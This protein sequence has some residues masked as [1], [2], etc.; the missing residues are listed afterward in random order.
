MAGVAALAGAALAAGL[1]AG[2]AGA[3]PLPPAAVAEITAIT[4]GPRYPNATWGIAID[5]A[6]TGERLYGRNAN[7]MFVPASITKLAQ[8]AAALQSYGP[9]HRLRTPVHR[10]GRVSGGRLDGVLSLV[11]SGDTSFGLRDRGN[12]LVYADGGADHNEAN[13]LGLVKSVSGDPLK[14]LNALAKSVRKSGITRASD[15]VIDDRLWQTQNWPDGPV[16]PMWVNENLIDITVR[17]GARGKRASISWRPRTAAYR[18]VSDVRT[19]TATN[20]E[21]GSTEEGVVRI[22]GTIAAGGGSTVR[23]Y[24]VDDAT[25]FARTAFIEALGRAGVRIDADATGTN[26]VAKLPR[27][28][29]YPAGTRLGQ[30][31]SAPLNQYVKVVLK[32]SYNRGADVLACLVGAKVGVRDCEQGLA[33]ATRIIQGLGVPASQFNHFD[34]AGSDDRNQD[35]PDALNALNRAAATQSWGADYRADMPQLG[36][37]GGGDIGTF[38]TTSPA[39]GA[40]QAKTGTRAAAAPG[41]PNGLLGSRGLSGYLVGASGRQMLITVIVNNV[42]FVQFDDLFAI[43]NDQ[44]GIVEAVYKAT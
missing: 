24:L 40:L 28:R 18:V 17:P 23:T 36:V 37:P 38:G 9:G 39:R 32:T 31:T 42:Q 43:I 3:A 15:V 21:V 27:S 12:T 14:A 26:P 13:S 19:G 16:G 22:S 11:A 25:A 35:T 29:T 2:T 10:V 6:V 5:D 20:L 41:V 1:A 44:V 34:G 33:R 30:W 4:D 8:G 7:Q